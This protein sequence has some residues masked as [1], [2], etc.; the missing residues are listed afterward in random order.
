MFYSA[1]SS[2][3]CNM[4]LPL[5]AT[6]NPATSSSLELA[7]LSLGPPAVSGYIMAARERGLILPV[8][9]ELNWSGK[10]NGGQHVEYAR[11]EELPFQVLG[12]IGMSLTATVEKIRCRRILLARKTMVCGKRLTLHNA[13]IEV[14]HLQKLKHPH[15]IQLVGSYMQGKRF[16]ILLYPVADFVT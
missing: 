14:Q 3:Y 11:G 4:S 8:D 10:S 13:L 2:P 6:Y 7:K 12:T 1:A 5:L 15:I 16:S 9:Q